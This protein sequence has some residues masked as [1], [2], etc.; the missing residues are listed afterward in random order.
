MEIAEA[1]GKLTEAVEK[2]PNSQVF[3]FLSIFANLA[4]IG[5][6]G[7]VFY[8]HWVLGK[9]ERKVRAHARIQTWNDPSFVS[10]RI[11]LHDQLNALN[12]TEKGNKFDEDENF[13]AVVIQVLNFFESL[14]QGIDEGVLDEGS[15]RR[16]F[17]GSLIPYCNAMEGLI[18]HLQKKYSDQTMFSD[19]SR[20]A[21]DWS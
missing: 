21:R 9:E 4:I 12:V 3:L 5:T 19:F 13:R 1:I 20:L 15:C 16:Y 7:F 8:Q 10:R 2:I 17:K 11:G 6:A 18:A 14:A